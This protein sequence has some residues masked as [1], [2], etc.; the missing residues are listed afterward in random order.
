[1]FLVLVPAM[2]GLM[3]GASRTGLA[4]HLPW[5]IGVGFWVLSSVGVWICLYA[6]S[7][8]TAFL[9]QRAQPPLWVILAAGALVGSIAGRYIIFGLAVALSDWIVDD[10]VPL[11]APPFELSGPFIGY[12]L[13]GW[14]GV[15]VIWTAL[16]HGFNAWHWSRKERIAVGNGAPVTPLLPPLA[17]PVSTAAAN[18][19]LDSLLVRLPPAIGRNIVALEAEDHYVRVHTM[20][21]T[22]L[23]HARFT[24]AVAAAAVLNGIRVHR[25]YWVRRDAIIEQQPQGRGMTLVLANNKRVPVSAGYRELVRQAGLRS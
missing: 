5:S 3:L 24:D 13:Q 6:G 15:F 14:A 25:S 8:A 22:A 23:V 9:L 7:V 2:I 20:L 12:Y 19:D 4:A 1:M 10:R 11:D 16:G 17:P 18:G 21:G